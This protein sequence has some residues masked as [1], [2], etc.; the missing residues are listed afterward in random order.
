MGHSSINK[1]KLGEEAHIHL[2][3]WKSELRK[4]GLGMEFFKRSVNFFLREFRLKRLLCEPYAENPAPNR[5]LSK[6]GFKLVKRYRTI[7]GVINFEQT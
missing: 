1:I 3:L 6:E 4:A 5:V 2:H 7:P